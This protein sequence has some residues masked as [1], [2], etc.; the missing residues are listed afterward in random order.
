MPKKNGYDFG[1]MVTAYNVRC[2]DG[3]TISP[4]AF[5][6]MDGV[7]VPLVYM[8]NHS[9]LNQVIGHADLVSV[10]DGVYGYCSLNKTPNGRTAKQILENGDVAALSI[11]A[12]SLR[13]NG[14]NVTHGQIKEVSLVLAGANPEAYIDVSTISHSNNGFEAEIFTAD[15]IEIYHDDMNY[16]EEDDEMANRTVGD[17]FN[18]MSEEQQAACLAIAEE[19]ANSLGYEDEAEYDDEDYEDEYDEYDENDEYDDE[20]YEDEDY[21]DEDYEMAQSDFGGYNNM[22]Y[23]A[24]ADNNETLVH[25]EFTADDMATILDDA[26]RT[27]SLR[28]SFLAHADSYGIDNIDYLFPDARTVE[29]TPQFISRDTNWVSVFM[30]QLYHTPFS[31]VKSIFADITETEARAKGYIKGNAKKD[32][33]FSLLKRATLPTTIYKKQKLDRDDLVDITSID[34]L[35]WVKAE[36]RFMFDEE[37]ARAILLGDGRLASDEDKISETCIRPIYTDA[38]LYSVKCPVNVAESDDEDTRARKFIKACIRQRKNYKGTGLPTLYTTE[39]QLCSML[40]IEDL[41]Q[42][43]IYDSVTTLATA[44]RVKEIVT[45]EVMED[46]YRDVKTGDSSTQSCKLLGI[47]VNPTDY[48]VGA[49]KGGAVSFFD[50]FD[51]SV[52]RQLYLM[53]ARCSGALRKPFSAL[54]ME[55]D[56]GGA[57]TAYQESLG[58]RTNL[59]LSN[60]TN[61]SGYVVKS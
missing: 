20:D 19:Y 9:D 1:G 32:E 47:I 23:N 3:V 44:L 12:N 24:F 29:A 6:D 49:D 26:K 7:R 37:L 36:M 41:N 30:G 38:D 42:R 52:N 13:K 57:V 39:D 4:G 48:G 25:S 5:D 22:K 60:T 43:R 51:L 11:Y 8:H 16:D 15:G 17:V 55:E 18:D 21:E 35:A 46:M 58:S 61:T 14:S 33:V 50:D 53:E 59:Q 28:D 10:D 27:G 56:V 31:R 34:A 2:S 54:V 40:L 45:V